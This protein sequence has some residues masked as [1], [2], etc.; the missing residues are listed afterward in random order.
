MSWTENSIHQ[1]QCVQRHGSV[2]KCGIHSTWPE[3]TRVRG[4]AGEG[5]RVQV[6]SERLHRA[7]G[8]TKALRNGSFLNK[9]F[10]GY[11]IGYVRSE[12]NHEQK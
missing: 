4:E 5:G 9:Q 6:S 12:G 7:G 3:L 2:S 8:G 10:G 1:I 11:N